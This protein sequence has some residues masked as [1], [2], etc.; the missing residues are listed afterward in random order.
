MAS[1]VQSEGQKVS[2]KEA[3]AVDAFAHALTQLPTIICDNAG[4][5]STH[6]H[7]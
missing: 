5:Q 6:G 2:G 7:W 3:L 1:A 4:G